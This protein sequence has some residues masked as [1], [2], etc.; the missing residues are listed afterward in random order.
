ML[1]KRKKQFSLGQAI[2]RCAENLLFSSSYTLSP[3]LPP[4][5]PSPSPRAGLVYCQSWRCLLWKVAGRADKGLR[6]EISGLI[7]P[8][9]TVP[10]VH[11]FPVQDQR[12]K[13]ATSWQH[14]L[15]TG[16]G[17]PHCPEEP[18]QEKVGRCCSESCLAPLKMHVVL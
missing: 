3:S 10:R 7:S 8:Q 4:A 1:R 14:G 6:T 16:L 2:L 17:P 13:R 15:E 9:H 18:E 11:P 5:T 12:H